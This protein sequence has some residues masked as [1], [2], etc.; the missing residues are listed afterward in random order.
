M[1]KK[2]I[3][4]TKKI[5]T[6]NLEKLHLLRDQGYEEFT[7]DFRNIDSSFVR[8]QGTVAALQTLEGHIAS[9]LG[10]TSPT[11]DHGCL[12]R[13]K[14]AGFLK[15]E[16]LKEYEHM[17]DFMARFSKLNLRPD[18]KKLYKIIVDE[19]DSIEEFHKNLLYIIKAHK[20]GE[21]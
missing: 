14:K 21:H 16:H 2:I 6:D 3:K 18:S 9:L 19:L 20:K 5:I 11:S 12:D 1:D 15:K 4:D 7:E 10:L 8:L 13:L 17:M